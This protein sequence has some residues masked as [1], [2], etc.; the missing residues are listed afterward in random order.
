M[1]ADTANHQDV[2][3]APEFNAKAAARAVLRA[4]RVGALGSLR[5][6]DG[7]PYTSMV[8]VAANQHG[9]PLTLIS[10][11][12]VHTQNVAAD[13]RASLLLDR[14]TDSDPSNDPMTRARIS[15]TG[16]MVKTEETAERERFL[17]YH[18]EASLYADFADFA[19]YRFEIESCHLV[20]G[21][22]RIVDLTR[23]DLLDPL[24]DSVELMA[25]EAG[26][27][28][29]MNDDHADAIDLYAQHFAEA[30]GDGFRCAACYPEGLALA[31][32]TE[33]L[34]VPFPKRI[35]SP[36][37]L[38]MALKTMAEEARASR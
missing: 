30:V 35:T 6:D 32:G 23:E 28:E 33:T 9:A 7:A 8:A 26:I 12:A 38:R 11:L 17:R 15:L 2:D 25:S 5:P 20:A 37:V 14:R 21:F 3:K 10:T 18:P 4:S 22:G 34:W 13:R 31:R 16:K 19:F 24:E 29:H 1:N 36:N 27:V